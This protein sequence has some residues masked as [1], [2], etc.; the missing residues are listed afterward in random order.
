MPHQLHASSVLMT[1]QRRLGVEFND[2]SLLNRALTHQSYINEHGGE[3]A[4]VESYERLEFLGDSVLNVS[5]A[6]R[7][8]DAMP[9]ADEGT[10]TLGRS[11]VVCRDSLSSVAK[12]LGLGEWV[13]FGRG[14]SEVTVR[15]SVLEDV[16]ESVLGAVYVDQG[17]FAAEHFITE[18][19]GDS[20]RDVIVNGVE[21]NPKSKFQ[22]AVQAY[23]LPTPR[24]S[25][26]LVSSVGD[27]P[28]RFEADVWVS[29]LHIATA[30]S[31]G[32]TRAEMVAAEEGI[33]IFSQGVPI[34]LRNKV[35]RPSPVS[36]GA[37]FA[38]RRY[39]RRKLQLSR[40]GD[41]A[42]PTVVHSPW[43]RLWVRLS[44]ALLPVR[45]Q[46]LR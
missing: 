45:A 35:R 33:E 22:E 39:P 3:D 36:P 19:L 43:R 44:S 16:Y 38:R 9:T 17:A 21:K 12:D 32:K 24:Y 2:V 4:E 37:S 28:L 14:E 41:V 7:L 30:V 15:D 8:F 46:D 42:A 26:R 1:V 27:Y 13:V 6:R 29:S 23:G 31:S 40:G 11:H 10:L 34:A 18:T 5:V 20:I 25:T